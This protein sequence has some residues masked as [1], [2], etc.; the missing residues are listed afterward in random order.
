M[1]KTALRYAFAFVLLMGLVSPAGA[2][3]LLQI[4][5]GSNL[6]AGGMGS[7]Y[8]PG[9]GVELLMRYRF[10]KPWA[11][12]GSVAWWRN[13]IDQGERQINFFH[14]P[15]MAFGEYYFLTKNVRPY[16]GA[17]VGWAAW[18]K[19]RGFERTTGGELMAGGYVGGF[20]LV[21]PNIA[22]DLRLLYRQFATSNAAN[23]AVENVPYSG[24]FLGCLGLT[25][26]V[27]IPLT[28]TV[29]PYFYE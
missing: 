20:F 3:L 10:V 26:G 9:F 28:R 7:I 17:E 23:N 11:I 19:E 21:S 4:G 14:T 12:G 22:L 6:L 8:K 27:I 18:G 5:G 15:L 24:G 2:Q 25:V 29:D 16:A 13:Q 1:K